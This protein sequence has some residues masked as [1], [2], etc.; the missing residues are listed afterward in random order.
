MQNKLK[1]TLFFFEVKKKK[2]K[3]ENNKMGEKRKSQTWFCKLH[4]TA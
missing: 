2:K 4:Y 3:N 1:T